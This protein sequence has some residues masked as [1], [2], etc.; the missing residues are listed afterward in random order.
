MLK[1]SNFGFGNY[2]KF[3]YILMLILKH[4]KYENKSI[5]VFRRADKRIW[6]VL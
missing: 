2:G 1:F 5:K 3:T 6:G 4:Y